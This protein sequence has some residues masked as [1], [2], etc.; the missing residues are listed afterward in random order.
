MSQFARLRRATLWTAG[1]VPVALLVAY[2]GLPSERTL[3]VSGLDDATIEAVEANAAGIVR[4]DR[5]VPASLD[6]IQDP[7]ARMQRLGPDETL[8]RLP[9]RPWA[10]GLG[11]GADHEAAGTLLGARYTFERRPNRWA[12]PVFVAILLVAA[13]CG[14]RWP[15]P[16]ATGR[17]R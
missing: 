9:P 2:L 16:A 17:A 8:L 15:G 11:M 10:A 5:S 14:L 13:L 12:G 7:L 6:R 4:V 3:V 1:F